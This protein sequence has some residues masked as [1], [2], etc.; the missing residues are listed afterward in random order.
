MRIMNKSRSKL[1][2]PKNVCLGFK[3]P[4]LK[5]LLTS[6]GLKWHLLTIWSGHLIKYTVELIYLHH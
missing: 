5:D 6:K 1:Q 2:K 4:I 3:K